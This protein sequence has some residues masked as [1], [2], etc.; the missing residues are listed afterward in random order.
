MRITFRLGQ[1][2][3]RMFGSANEKRKRAKVIENEGSA[4][5]TTSALQFLLTRSDLRAL[6][7]TPRSQDQRQLVPNAG[8]ACDPQQDV[9]EV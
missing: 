7:N 4:A 5:A 6:L 9:V 2:R 1:H 8:D 3:S